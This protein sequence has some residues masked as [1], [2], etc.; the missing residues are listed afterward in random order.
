MDPL[1]PSQA[2][3]D[4]FG[5][6]VQMNLDFAHY[7]FIDD[8][9]KM[10]MLDPSRFDSRYMMIFIRLAYQKREMLKTYSLVLNYLKTVL[11]QDTLAP[12]EN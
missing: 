10:F 8:H 5:Q 4:Q 3:L 2:D 9:V 11:P 7:E 12:Y 6:I 1:N